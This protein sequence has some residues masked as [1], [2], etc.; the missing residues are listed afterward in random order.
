MIWDLSGF[1][2]REIQILSQNDYRAQR[3]AVELSSLK[4]SLGL[5]H[6]EGSC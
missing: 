5:S 2:L 4:K 3:Q 1:P 6:S